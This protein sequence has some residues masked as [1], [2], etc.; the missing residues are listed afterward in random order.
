VRNI[1]LAGHLHHGKSS[2]MD[3][4]VRVTHNFG[5]KLEHEF[6]RKWAGA[7]DMRY[8]DTRLDEQ[9]RRLSIKGIPMSL[10]L[11]SSSGKSYALN[12]MDTPGHANFID[13]VCAACR[14]ADGMI[15]V[16]D[17]VEGVMLNTTRVIKQAAA[18]KIPV[19]LVINKIDRLVLELKLPPADAYFKLKHVIEEVNAVL[20]AET[21][22][23]NA[24]VSLQDQT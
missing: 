17:A 21:G 19:C 5:S 15:L 2:I 22:D 11:P 16:V 23:E 3:M 10:L 4:L 7:E 24:A 13:E 6:E 18:Q 20:I 1:V 14:I 12:I 8:T 9:K